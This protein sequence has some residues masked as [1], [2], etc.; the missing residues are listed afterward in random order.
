MYR[1]FLRN[2]AEVTGAVTGTIEGQQVTVPYGELFVL[3]PEQLGQLG[4]TAQT[5][6]ESPA[7]FE[8]PGKPVFV[9]LDFI[10]LFTVEE[11]LAIIGATMAD[12]AVK[13]WYDKALG[14]SYI[15]LTDQRTIDGIS[16]LVPA[17][18]L[19]EERA[20]EILAAV[21]PA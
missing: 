14:A 2:G 7:E 15:D 12:P 10:N 9:W 11:Q 17:G 20:A 1:R 16:A 6:Y 4:L 8:Q 13:L 19:T 18:L 5:I 21:Q 3:T